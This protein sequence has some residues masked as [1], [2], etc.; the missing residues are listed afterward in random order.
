[1]FSFLGSFVAFRQAFLFL[2]KLLVDGRV[3]GNLSEAHFNLMSLAFPMG[4]MMA[5][6]LLIIF[7]RRSK[8][9]KVQDDMPVAA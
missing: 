9:F 8:L 1:M 2:V 5:S 6:A 7:Y 4:W 3:I